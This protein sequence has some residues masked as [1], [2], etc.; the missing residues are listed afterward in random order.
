MD[1]FSSNNIN[2][3]FYS[4]VESGLLMPSI[5][6][7]EAFVLLEIYSIDQHPFHSSYKPYLGTIGSLPLL[8][9]ASFLVFLWLAPFL[10]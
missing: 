5:D 8:A 10:L 2:Q 7:Q 9:K 1:H 4:V 6:K 3:A